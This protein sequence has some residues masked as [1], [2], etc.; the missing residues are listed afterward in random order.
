MTDHPRRLADDQT[1]KQV[2]HRVMCSAT[3]GTATAYLIDLDDQGTG[4]IRAKEPVRHSTNGAGG[5]TATGLTVERL[6]SHGALDRTCA[7]CG[8]LEIVICMRCGATSCGTNG[9][10]WT[11]PSC[12]DH[13]ARLNVID[14]TSISASEREDRP[15][16]GHSRKDNPR[17]SASRR[18]ALPPPSSGFQ[19]DGD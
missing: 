11:C 16:L 19:R 5:G 2:T 9:L 7:V 12:H 6:R 13:C 4:T 1:R 15:A 18:D 8:N 10:P 3:L 17:L 14:S